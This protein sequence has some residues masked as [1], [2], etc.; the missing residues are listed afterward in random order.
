MNGIRLFLIKGIIIFAVVVQPVVASPNGQGSTGAAEDRD[1]EQSTETQ[2]SK[3]AEKKQEDCGCEAKTPPDVLATVGGVKILVKDVDESI[4][5]RIKELQSQV[6]EA[7]KRQL[8]LEINSRL[9]EAEAKRLGITSERL[10]EREISEKVKEPSEADARV[11]YDQNRSRI[12]GEFSQIKDQIIGYL[13]NQRQQGEAKKLADRL[14]SSAEVKVLAESVT[15]PETDAGRAR[16]LATVNGKAITSGDVENAL[17][18][19]VYSVQDQVYTLRKQS[20]DVKINDLL[21]DQEAKKKNVTAEAL[22]DAEILPRVKP[23]TEADAHSFYEEN[24]DRAKGSF[25]QLRPQ[26]IQ[27]LQTREQGNAAAAYAEQLRK[28]ATLQ[29][30]LKPPDPPV[31]EISIDNRP[32]TGGANARVT[33]VEFTDFECPSCAATQP[34][35]EELVKE[36]GDKV[37]LVERSY[38]L[39]QHKHAFKAAEAAEA[40]REQGKYWEYAAV[41]FKNQTALE[42][43]KLKE[44]ASQLGLDRKKFDAALDSGKYSDSVKRDVA[45]GD[46]VGVDSTP[47]VFIN[48]KRTLDKS[49]EA[50]KSAIEA[51]FTDGVKK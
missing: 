20:L 39:D 50:L 6:I 2:P 3:P 42:I 31:L 41:L 8:D 36:F 7:R 29:V 44:Y 12:E 15:P 49:R 16:V 1:A 9:L 17:M 37:K 51:A 21:L 10:L 4:N 45:A 25:E 14:R 40:A 5:D 11:F 24:K 28:G 26:I 13:R 48:G 47:T 27:Y 19:L 18:P 23:V 38:P 46:K 34:V 32:W 43:D 33:I 35:L 22:F 30:F